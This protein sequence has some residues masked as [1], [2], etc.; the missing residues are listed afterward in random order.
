MNFV[1]IGGIP[2]A[3]KNWVA[4]QLYRQFGLPNH[5]I[6]KLSLYSGLKGEE[7]WYAFEK[8]YQ[9]QLRKKHCPGAVFTATFRDPITRQKWLNLVEPYPYI[10][11][12]CYY[13]M[14]PLQLAIERA[15][16]RANI[17][18]SHPIR[19]DVARAN[20]T[21]WY[22][23]FTSQNNSDLYE[24]QWTIVQDG[25]QILNDFSSRL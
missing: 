17:D 11:L 10:Q 15:I 2:G 20:I 8:Q 9:R 23:R 18:S 5:D 7:L 25:Q 4:D 14:V 19:A 6:D 12:S 3:G 21:A 13:I 22:D 1:L 24:G 16:N